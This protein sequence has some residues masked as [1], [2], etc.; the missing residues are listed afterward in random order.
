MSHQG[1]IMSK[2]SAIFSN[3][4]CPLEVSKKASIILY[5]FD[6]QSP[7]RIIPFQYICGNLKHVLKVLWLFFLRGGLKSSPRIWA[8]IVWSVVVMLWQCLGLGVAKLGTLTFYVLALSFFKLI[9]LFWKWE[10][11]Q[12][13]WGAEREGERQPQAGTLLS[14]QSLLRVSITQ[15]MRLWPEP[16]SGVRHL[17]N[18]A[19]LGAPWHII[20]WKPDITLGGSQAALRRHLCREKSTA[21]KKKKKILPP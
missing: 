10:R 5:F 19:T 2:N 15:T 16:K 9:Y 1:A 21:R 3:S 20:S 7:E 11:A 4:N 12:E 18:W 6:F 14:V 13:W 17:T 8:L